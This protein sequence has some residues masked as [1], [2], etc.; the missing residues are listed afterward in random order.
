M[1][2]VNSNMAWYNFLLAS[3][4]SQVPSTKLVLVA[5]VWS[6]HI[7]KKDIQKD[8]SRTDRENFIT[9]AKRKANLRSSPVRLAGKLS[10]LSN[11]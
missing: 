7:R 11:A 8:L 5:L 6:N 2:F 3:W 4:Q 10:G 1:Y 9:I